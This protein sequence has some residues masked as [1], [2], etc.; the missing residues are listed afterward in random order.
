MQNLKGVKDDLSPMF[1]T[2]TNELKGEI[3]YIIKTRKRIERGHWDKL[4]KQKKKW[5]EMTN[6]ERIK[7]FGYGFAL[8]FI[9]N[10][11]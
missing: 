3:Q 5:S 6:Q 2:Y 8:S 7:F 9:A 10:I 1:K 4:I 11:I